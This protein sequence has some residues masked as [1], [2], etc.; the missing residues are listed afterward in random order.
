MD[1]LFTLQL[2]LIVHS[3]CFVWTCD[4]YLSCADI[5]WSCRRSIVTE[6]N[7]LWNL[8]C[9]FI[10]WFV[11]LFEISK[12]HERDWRLTSCIANVPSWRHV[13]KFTRIV[14]THYS[15]LIKL[16]HN[17]PIRNCLEKLVTSGS[18]ADNGKSERPYPSRNPEKVQIVQ[19][20]LPRV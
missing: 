2:L 11:N 5:F 19:A 16:T 15:D 8:Y 1:K 18:V 7:M 20:H 10:F 13:T 6:L 17:K 14:K 9:L 12:P 3:T 4:H